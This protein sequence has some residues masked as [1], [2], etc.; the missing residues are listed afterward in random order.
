MRATDADRE[1]VRSILQDAH[2]EGRLDWQEFDARTTALLNAQTYDQLA[3]LTA[4]LPS[5]VPASP[6]MV[7]QPMPGGAGATNGMAV[8][9]LICGIAQFLGFWLLGTIPAIVLGHM[10]RKEIRQT[11][12][13]GA[14]MAMAGL[15]LGYVGVALTI[16]FAIFIAYI[17]VAASHNTINGG[18]GGVSG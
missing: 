8:G 4:D 12:E 6:P 7:Y 16:L 1:N 5:R 13:R 2:V 15:V 11:G 17:A 14:G 3:A 9:A 18:V 10:A